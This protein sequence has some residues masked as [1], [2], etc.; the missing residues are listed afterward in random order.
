M[1]KLL[2]CVLLSL[3][4][5]SAKTPRPAS[6]T[7]IH[8]EGGKK[9]LLS[10]YKGKV[11][12]FAILATSCDHCIMSMEMLNKLQKQ[13]GP[14]GFQVV[15]AIGDEKAAYMLV[16]FTQRYKPSYP[17]GYVDR[18]EIQKLG[19]VPSD[20]RPFVPI[21]LFIDRSNQVRFQFYGD[22]PFFKEFKEE[23]KATRLIVQA[24]LKR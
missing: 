7:P 4:L 5:V 18:E 24:L 1:R 16:P 17:M 14:Q 23:E 2:L 13:F 10:Q 21:F 12:L 19:D 6:T 22:E 8:L 9:L 20:K 15:T 11:V 3:T